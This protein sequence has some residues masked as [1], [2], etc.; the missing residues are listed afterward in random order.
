VTTSAAQAD[1]FYTEAVAHS[2]VW[3]VRDER[4]YPAP[5]G[6]GG[7]RAHPFWSSQARAER[8]IATVTAYAGMT[9][10]RIELTTWRDRW[11]PGLRRDG[12]LVGL[13]W[14]GARAT[15]YDVSPDDALRAL[16]AR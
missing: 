2:A 7:R 4:G 14:S 5:V 12:F 15:G 13:N 6:D 9:A 1:A 10:E 3:T 16:A 11:L 8:V